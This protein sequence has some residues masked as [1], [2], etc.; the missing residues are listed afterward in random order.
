[1]TTTAHPLIVGAGLSGLAMARWCLREG[2]A[3][4]T[5]VDTRSAAAEQA[6]NQLPHIDVLHHD[7]DQA[8][9][10][11]VSPSAVYMS[12]GLSPEATQAV[13]QWCETQ[14]VPMGNELTLFTAA[15]A[16]HQPAEQSAPT[17]LGI[18]GTNGKTTVTALT[19]HLLEATGIVA[20]AAGNIGPTL[21]DTLT[22]CLNQQSWPRAWVLELSSFQLHGAHDFEPSMGAILN[23]SEDHLDWHPSMAAYTQAK[24]KV[25]G[26]RAKRLL[27]R[28]DPLVMAF[29][30]ADPPPKS[31]R[32]KEPEALPPVWHSIGLSVPE[33]PGDWGVE[34]VNG[35]A[36]LVRARGLDTGAVDPYCGEEPYIQRLMPAE[37]LR[38][39][40]QHNWVNALAALALASEVTPDVAA[41]LYGLRE[42]AGE[43]HRVQPVHVVDGVAFF[44]DSKGTNVGATV[45]A[46]KGLGADHSLVV[47]LGGQ[48]K[49]Q[50]FSPLRAP[51]TRFAKAVVLLGEAREALQSMLEGADLVVEQVDDMAE[52][53]ACAHRLA[54]SGD[55]VLLSP[56]CA[57][58]DMFRDYADRGNQFANQ[59]HALAQERGVP[60]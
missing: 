36:W 29:Q 2:A 58:F 42:Y 38:I 22:E 19:A 59:V 57:S 35:M 21:L 31:K 7:L 40:G 23:I 53:V 28:D 60:Q 47:I 51:L 32:R 45:A 43:P 16:N 13:T 55:A 56:A 49:G 48:G 3:S 20:K 39:R 5:L 50:D 25:W 14:G 12:P 44:D 37:A 54:V 11:Q 15:L 41:L 10:Q 46:L 6:R 33:R 18:T 17:V 9:M 24:A 52:A 4:V 30:P 27:N 34:W 1:M 8:L 26:Q